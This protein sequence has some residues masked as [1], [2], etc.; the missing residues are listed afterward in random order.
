MILHIF[1]IENPSDLVFKML[2][3]VNAFAARKPRKSV[4]F[5]LEFERWEPNICLPQVQAVHGDGNMK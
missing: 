2:S 4:D 5:A 3:A 1:Q